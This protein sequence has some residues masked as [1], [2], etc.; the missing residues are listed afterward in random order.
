MRSKAAKYLLAGAIAGVALAAASLATPGA[1]AE[2]EPA[3]LIAYRQSI[4][5]AI[6]GHMGAIA[7]VAKGEVSFTDE[8]AFH[9]GAINEMSKHLARLFPEGSGKEAGD[10]RALPVI[11]EKWDDFT[12]AAENLGVLSEKLAEVA[13]SGDRALIASQ[14][15]ELGKKGC[16]G[17]HETFREKKN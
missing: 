14:T 9:A 5:K 17:C 1:R 10:T 13:E 2:D 7:M 6:G 15:G 3:A 4:M 16:G 12:A 8:V 11:W